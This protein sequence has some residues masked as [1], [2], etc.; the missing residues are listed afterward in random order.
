TENAGVAS[1]I[2]AL[3]TFSIA[4]CVRGRPDRIVVRRSPGV[5]DTG[6]TVSKDDS[7]QSGGIAM[8]TKEM[9]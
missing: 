1:S 7:A 4:S 2:L 3:G 5:P 6:G 8:T 9:D